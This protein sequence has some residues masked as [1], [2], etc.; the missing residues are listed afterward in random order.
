MIIFF[1]PLFKEKMWGG[2]NLER[3]FGFA[4]PAKNIGECWGI[5]A[6]PH[7]E[8]KVKKGPFR[9][10]K[11]S[12]LY[13]EHPELFGH[14]PSSSFPILVKIIDAAQDLSIQV[15]PDDCRAKQEK[16]FGKSECW[17]VLHAEKGAD[18]IIGHKAKDK[19]VLRRAVLEQS[20]ENHVQRVPVQKDDFFF[21]GAGTLHGINKGVLLLEVQQSSDITY[22]FYDYGRKLAGKE[23]PLHIEEALSVVKVPDEDVKRKLPLDAA[24]GFGIIE[25]EGSNRR[26]AHEHGD[27]LAVLAGEGTID[28]ETVQKGDFLMVSARSPYTLEGRLQIAKATMKKD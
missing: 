14:F 22:R 15:H 10:T 16:S 21:I 27:Y 24:F 13:E 11:L 1:E 9:G 6:H 7:G 2:D 12:T 18:I 20:L 26:R 19:D 3:H 23:R 28:G 4:L 17:Y 5:S 8:T 25:T